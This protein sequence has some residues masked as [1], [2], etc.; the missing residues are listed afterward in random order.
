[1]KHTLTAAILGSCAFLF[2][3]STAAGGSAQLKPRAQIGAQSHALVRASAQITRSI[4]SELSD[5]HQQ[6]LVAADQAVRADPSDPWAYYVLGDALVS[7]GRT[8][9]AIAAFRDA[10]RRF[11]DS[12]QW[13]TSLAIWGQA[14]ALDQVGRC[15]DAAAAY[16]RYAAFAERRD[17]AGAQ[18]ARAQAKQCVPPVPARY[19]SL[20]NQ[21]AS[22]EAVGN[23]K[24]SLE[25]ADQ[26]IHTDQNDG[27]AQYL[28]GDALVSLRRFDEALA[29][30]KQAERTLPRDYVW[31]RSVTIWGE[32]N[33]LREAG[34]CTEASPIYERY[35]AFVAGQD[36][37]GAAL[38]HEYA[39]R[40]CV[41]L[42]KHGG[43]RAG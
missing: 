33:A 35:A 9:D 23:P 14:N 2:A 11:G 22:F 1:V 7:M 20:D 8:D 40:R 26:A 38:G 30:F 28:R 3:S 17:P 4:Q 13:G 19:S 5:D 36:P 16:E 39:K 6:A 41:P 21:A 29:S 37:K 15:K 43:T 24:R 27:W 18:L 42:V 34:R 32:A 10:E 25:L 12:D 31:E